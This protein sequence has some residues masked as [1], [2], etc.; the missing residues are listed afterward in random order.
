M[1][2]SSGGRQK[3]V[4]S[5][6][7]YL[8]GHHANFL[9]SI[10]NYVS[11][12]IGE[13]PFSDYSDVEVNDAFFGVGYVVSSFPSLYDMFGK[14]MAG[15]DVDALYSQLFED[16]IN[17]SEVSDLVSAEASLLEDD[18]ETNIIPRLQTGMRDI[19]SIIAS[20]FV[21][22]KTL[23][24]DTR[25]KQLAK[26]SAELKYR[27]LPIVEDRWKM[28]LEWNRSVIGIYSE[29]MKLYYSAKMDID[30]VNTSMR[31]K[32][33]LWPFTVLDFQRAAVG[34][35]QGGM[36]ST[37]SGTAGASQTSKAIGGAL[38][39]AG[40]MAATGNPYAIAAGAVVGLAMA[41]L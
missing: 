12:T 38:A 29:M 16:T 17:T 15:L 28:H 7:P 25:V 14:F 35:L 5:Y 22:G 30:E 23:I 27:L 31:A 4:V 18:I 37:T 26:F 20:S 11:S 21:I 10:Q 6:S 41:Y 24:E 40:A 13:S 36:S 8:E 3:T 39:G 2:G 32:D 19:N 1:G 33:I 9:N 34:A